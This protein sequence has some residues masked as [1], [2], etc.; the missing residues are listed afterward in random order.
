MARA[1][2][3]LMIMKI[4]YLMQCHWIRFIGREYYKPTEQGA[5]ARFKEA[6]IALRMEEVT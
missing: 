1:I 6:L 3:M 5:E 4:D 2:D